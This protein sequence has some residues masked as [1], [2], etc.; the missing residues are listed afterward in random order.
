MIDVSRLMNVSCKTNGEIVAQCPACAAA[1]GDSKGDHL[2]VFPDGKFGCVAH[3]KDKAHNRK[4]LKL[5][6]HRPT[7]GFTVEEGYGYAVSPSTVPNGGGGATPY[8]YGTRPGRR[9]AL[10]MPMIPDSSDSIFEVLR[11]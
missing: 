11:I 6:G 5:V 1:G 7:H 10:L 3:S 2:I 9:L 8:T 4:I